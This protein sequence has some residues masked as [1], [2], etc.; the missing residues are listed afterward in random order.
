MRFLIFFL[1]SF[2]CFSNAAWAQSEPKV[3]SKTLKQSYLRLLLDFPNHETDDWFAIKLNH[4]AV[5]HET[6]PS[7]SQII[8]FALERDNLQNDPDIRKALSIIEQSH[9][10]T[11]ARYHASKILRPLT[12]PDN[13][14]F[15]NGSTSIKTIT[16]L[17]DSIEIDINKTRKYCTAESVNAKALP[18][19]SQ[20]LKEK[21]APVLEEIHIID[22]QEVRKAGNRLK[23]V[24]ISAQAV[25]DGWLTGYGAGY[26][27][28]RGLGLHYIPEDES[29]P[30]RYLMQGTIYAI[31]P[32]KEKKAFFVLSSGD[33][34]IIGSRN[35][36]NDLEIKLVEQIDPT[37]FEITPY[38]TLPIG[39]Q[40][41]TKMDNGDLFL[42]FGGS[43]EF[44][45][46]I[47]RSVQG[48]S[49]A[50]SRNPPIGFTNT[51][52]IYDPCVTNGRKF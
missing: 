2:E 42:Y 40:E 25:S 20:G 4:S 16:S 41:I 15:S 48:R 26:G 36:G 7:L 39:I 8:W 43:T 28:I 35:L 1:L 3:E 23:H 44:N 50:Y 37:K 51:G 22:N 46:Y 33:R 12:V 38:R 10:V 30:T 14:T 13:S 21:L 31:I 24:P 52:Q 27:G 19:L 6:A 45:Y 47:S 9:P 11:Q 17:P 49:S 18:S 32:H 29:L 34:N 5:I